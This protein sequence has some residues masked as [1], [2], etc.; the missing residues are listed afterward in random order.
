MKTAHKILLVTRLDDGIYKSHG[1]GERQIVAKFNATPRGLIRAID[2]LGSERRQCERCYG[3]IGC[4]SSWLE[5]DGVHI[6]DAEIRE[7]IDP[8]F[9]AFS[10]RDGENMTRTKEAQKCLERLVPTVR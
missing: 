10:N 5:L 3:N 9:I 1:G 7:Q 6:D 4:G 2:A 8:G